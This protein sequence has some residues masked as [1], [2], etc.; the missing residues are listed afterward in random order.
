[1][2][3]FRQCTIELQIVITACH[4]KNFESRVYVCVYLAYTRAREDSFFKKESNPY[5]IARD[6]IPFRAACRKPYHDACRLAISSWDLK[7]A[8]RQETLGRPE[9]YSVREDMVQRRSVITRN[10]CVIFREIY[11]AI[12]D[13]FWQLLAWFLLWD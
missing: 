13:N 8:T 4:L 3:R 12:F 2:F 10:Y 11:L 1:M 7:R 6:L 9:V 5:E